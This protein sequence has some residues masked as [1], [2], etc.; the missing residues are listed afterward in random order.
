MVSDLIMKDG[1]TYTRLTMWNT[2]QN[3]DRV[4]IKNI[5]GRVAMLWEIA[6]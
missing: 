4:N 3:V 5:P 2:S 1:L 6:Q